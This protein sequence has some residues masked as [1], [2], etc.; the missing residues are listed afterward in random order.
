MSCRETADSE[1]EDLEVKMHIVG[2]EPEWRFDKEVS[3]HIYR[4]YVT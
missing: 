2:D 4:Q 1:L 3:F